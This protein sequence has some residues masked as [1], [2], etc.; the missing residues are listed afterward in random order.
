M[1]PSERQNRPE[2]GIF[3]TS[4]VGSSLSIQPSDKVDTIP[5]IPSQ[6]SLLSQQRAILRRAWTVGESS[7]VSTVSSM[8]DQNPQQ[9]KTYSTNDELKTIHDLISLKSYRGNAFFQPGML[10]RGM[11]SL[12]SIMSYI[13]SG[14]KDLNCDGG[15]ADADAD[16][17]LKDED[18]VWP[19]SGSSF[20]SFDTRN[21]QMVDSSR[22]RNFK[23]KLM[24]GK[25]PPLSP[26]SSG[27]IRDA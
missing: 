15:G 8:K 21:E 26:Q 27:D 23:S 2:Q 20:D 5:L 25:K 3:R 7:S 10:D 13:S 11:Q 14:A 16:V 17:I 1:D 9:S 24:T 4:N 6:S 19:V 12:S 22:H 18:F